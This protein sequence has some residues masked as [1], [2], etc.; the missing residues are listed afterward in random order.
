MD[1]PTGVFI[2]VIIIGLVGLW[3][4]FFVIRAA[5]TDAL[6]RHDRATQDKGP[7]APGKF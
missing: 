1:D 6:K 7:S 2:F 4:Q 3:I 5:I